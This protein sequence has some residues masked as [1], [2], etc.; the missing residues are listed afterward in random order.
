MGLH[1]F[2]YRTVENCQRLCEGYNGCVAVD[3]N[4]D[5]DQPT[6][7]CYLHFNPENQNQMYTYANVTHYTVN[8]SNCNPTNGIVYLIYP[9]LIA[10]LIWWAISSSTLL[11]KLRC[12]FFIQG[13]IHS[14][15]QTTSIAPLQVYFYS[16]ALPTEHGYCAGVSRRSATGN[17]E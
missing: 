10:L 17:C 11:D 13:Y 9:D 1:Y 4:S 5:L 6:G 2:E 8:E 15:I 16:E 3:F 14:F 7:G 12:I